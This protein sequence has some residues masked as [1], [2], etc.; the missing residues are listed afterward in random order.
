LACG[1]DAV[2]KAKPVAGNCRRVFCG[3]KT[4]NQSHVFSHRHFFCAALQIISLVFAARHFARERRSARLPAR[5]A[6]A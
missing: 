3:S 5:D 6:A 4:L 2:P 1:D